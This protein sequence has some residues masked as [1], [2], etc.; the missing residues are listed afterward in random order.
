MLQH[1]VLLGAK[2]IILSEWINKP[3]VT[4]GASASGRGL[5]L[6]K[7]LDPYLQVFWSECCEVGAEAF[8]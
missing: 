1:K 8:G 6:Y 2:R 4:G 7:S 3:R 5:E